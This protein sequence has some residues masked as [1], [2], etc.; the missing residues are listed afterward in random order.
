MQILHTEQQ[1]LHT[2]H[3]FSIKTWTQYQWTY[4]SHY[5]IYHACVAIIVP[6]IVHNLVAIIVPQILSQLSCHESSS[7]HNI[8][9]HTT[10]THQHTEHLFTS[11]HV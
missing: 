10:T 5:P 7:T 2:V 4:V 1:I 11:V 9:E 3:L 8:S 6:Q